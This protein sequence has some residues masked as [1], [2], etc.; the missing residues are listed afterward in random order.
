VREPDLGHVY[1]RNDPRT[2][3]VHVCQAGSKWERDHLLF[4]DYLRAKPEAA[5]EYEDVKR[6][7]AHAH[8]SDRL[9]YT[10]AKGP[11]IERTLA[12]AARWAHDTSW[13][14]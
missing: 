4:R 14:P 8:G 13:E 7:A 12:A 2:I 1:F 6:A 3:Q 5:R 11:F 9:A 10:E